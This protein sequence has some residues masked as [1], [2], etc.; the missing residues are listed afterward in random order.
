MTD[1][2]VIIPARNEEFLQQTIDDILANIRGDSE[3]IVMLDG[4]WPS[5]GIPMHPRVQVVHHDESIGQRQTVNEG[6]R[7]SEARFIM[8]ADAHCAFDEGF[9]AKLMADC[10]YDWTVIPR[11]Y[12]LHA[13]DWECPKCGRRWMQGPR[14]EACDQCDNTAGFEKQIVWQPKLRKRSDYARFDRDMKFQYW[15]DFEKRSEAAGDI[16]DMMCSVGA[17]FFMHRERFW[18]LG[19]LDEA[20]GSWGQMGVEI[21]CKSWLSG[22]RQVVNKKT[23]FSHLF[24]TQKGFGFPYQISGKQVAAARR[25][26]QDMWLNDKWPGAVRKLSWLLDHFAP[27][28]E[29]HDDAEEK[30]VIKTLPA[31]YPADDYVPPVASFADPPEN[32]T[33]SLVYYTD[34]R[35]EERIT[36]L[37]R[38]QLLKT[39]PQWQIVSVSQYPIDFGQNIVLAQPRGALT[40]FEQILAGL[41]A[42]TADVVFLVEHDVIYHPSHFDFTPPRR[43]VFY[44]NEHCYKVDAKTG[45][46]LFFYT[47]QTSGVCAYRKLLLEHYERR[48]ARVQK[49]GFTR[50]MGF[51]P[52][53]HKFPRG[54]D[55]YPA[56]RWMSEFPNV[57][58]RHASN[59]TASRFKKEEYRSQRSIKGWKLCDDIPGWGKTK[60]RFDEWCYE[61][62][63]SYAG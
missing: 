51:E 30:S 14:P 38:R 44:Y 20:H 32:L 18:E 47:K 10:E 8:K 12:N 36:K 53:T 45:Q 2:S 19:G 50:R 21:A 9:D 25:H 24:R 1:L 58:V 4:Y 42:S 23:W 49:E 46:A 60:D 7:I 37:V 41:R 11:M 27:V 29:W 17:C 39:C 5:V 22:G 48:V 35:C 57:D 34:N 52:G 61:L 55:D 6:A 59:L 15:R 3:V 40:M 26:S 16:T 28:P 31:P 62:S 43:D 54:I 33:K 56:E 13:F 63:K